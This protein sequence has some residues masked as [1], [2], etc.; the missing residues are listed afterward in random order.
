M[1][2]KLIWPHKL[3]LQILKKPAAPQVGFT[4]TRTHTLALTALSSLFIIYVLYVCLLNLDPLWSL[5][6][7]SDLRERARGCW[8]H[9]QT[10]AKITCC[11]NTKPTSDGA[12]EG[13]RRINSIFREYSNDW[14]APNSHAFPVNSIWFGSDSHVTN[15][16]NLQP[17]ISHFSSRNKSARVLSQHWQQNTRRSEVPRLTPSRC[18]PS[19]PWRVF[20][21]RDSKISRISSS[22]EY[23]LEK[24]D[25]LATN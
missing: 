12:A 20:S 8:M 18:S 7:R 25:I 22:A 13:R 3:V 16:T 24:S 17:L 23:F 4:H 21:Y 5:M 9:A 2:K 14:R 6:F 11:S 1:W 10:Q 19:D 15:L